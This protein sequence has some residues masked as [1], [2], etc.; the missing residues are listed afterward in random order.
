[1]D[2]SLTIPP[3]PPKPAHCGIYERIRARIEKW[4]RSKN[5]RNSRWVD[6]LLALPDFVRLLFGLSLDPDV[7]VKHKA[8]LGMV[9]AYIL[10][11]IDIVPEALFGPAGYV[12][13]LALVAYCINQLV[14]HVDPRLVLRH[15]YGRPD[16][17]K[18]C[19]HIIAVAD[20]MIGEGL[21]RKVKRFA[22]STPE[23]QKEQVFRE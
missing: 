15:W 12:D 1:M 9:L 4:A 3:T 10:S 23:S 6:Q 20:E 19:R 8:A 17:L 22:N 14:N 21:W 13:D 11:P 18:F 16:L 7:P 5:G 2:S